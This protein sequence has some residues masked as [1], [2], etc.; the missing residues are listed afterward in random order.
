MSAQKYHYGHKPA[1]RRPRKALVILVCSILLI[2]LV[3]GLIYLDLR[4]HVS[5]SV[6]GETRTVS[7]VLNENSQQITIDEPFY[8]FELP[9]DWKE[10]E[11]DANNHYT[12][13]KWQA[14]IPGKD[15]RWLE[16]FIDRIPLNRPLNRLVAVSAQGNELR[17][18][19]ISDNCSNF[20]I[21]G[22]FDTSVA[23]GL[24]PTL[25]K[26]NKV[27]FL[28]NLPRVTDN[29]VGTGSEG[30]MNSVTVA[31]RNKGSHKYFFVYTDR[32]F[33]PDYNIL[34]DALKSFRAK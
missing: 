14:T 17:F 30:S 12:S 2:C 4:K 11:R 6:E 19:D 3:V 28:C 10:I 33:Q 27:D 16:L 8:T 13:I 24:K 34:Y 23:S 26:W 7:Q 21:G 20:T 22:T 15:N 18:S 1:K 9:G 5:P 32:N 25:T 31:G 29:E